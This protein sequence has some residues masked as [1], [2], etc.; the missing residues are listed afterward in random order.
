MTN[1]TLGAYSCEEPD[2]TLVF[3]GIVIHVCGSIG[4]NT[5]QNVQAMALAKLS[6][7][8][9]GMPWK[10]NMWNVGC[11][12]FIS[13]SI[14]NFV[15]LTLAPASILV[16]LESVQFISNVLFGKFIRK[17]DIPTSMWLGV[18]SMIAGT[19]FAVIFGANESVCFDVTKLVSY[20]SWSQ[21][22]AWWVY[23]ALTFSLSFGCLALHQRFEDDIKAGITS[24]HR[25]QLMPVVFAIPS[26]LLGGAQVC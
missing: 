8:E 17:I 7:R 12:V 24:K 11:A 10:S 1:V 9:K 15:A 23:I 2:N 4:I 20:W 26:A 22:W 6:G 19:A 21:G 3:I 5:G 25:A 16:P 13:C 14:L 18:S